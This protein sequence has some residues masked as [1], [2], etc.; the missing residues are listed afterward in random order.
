M[1]TAADRGHVQL[2]LGA[3]VLG[4]L[5]AAEEAAV[6]AHLDRCAQCRD[7][8]EELACVPSFLD[9]LG[10]DDGAPELDPPEV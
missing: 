8:Y 9:L 3:Y 2:Q 1:A 5:S 6:Q 4:G 10:G 7:E